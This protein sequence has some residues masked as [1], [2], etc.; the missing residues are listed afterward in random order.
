M[1]TANVTESPEDFLRTLN[2]GS[3]PTAAIILAE[4]LK[5]EAEL[6]QD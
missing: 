2:W 6:R 5:A 3:A 4:G 1:T